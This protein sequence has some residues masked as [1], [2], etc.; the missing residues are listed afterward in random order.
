MLSIKKTN[1]GN[2]PTNKETLEAL[3]RIADG[4][5][6]LGVRSDD[7]KALKRHIG[8]QGRQIGW[9]QINGKWVLHK[10][11]KYGKPKS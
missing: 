9:E 1:S 6:N 2:M 7:L 3:S 8:Q 5:W 11:Y 4:L 10:T